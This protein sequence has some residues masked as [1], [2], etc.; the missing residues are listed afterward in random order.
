MV[1]ESIARAF[2]GHGGGAGCFRAKV[3][4]GEVIESSSRDLTELAA[5]PRYFSGV[6]ESKRA[7]LE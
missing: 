2:S 6:V 7:W 4:C 3:T 5:M 1:T